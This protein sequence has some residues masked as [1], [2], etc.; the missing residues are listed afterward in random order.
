MRYRISLIV[1]GIDK[2]S[3]FFIIIAGLCCFFLMLLTCQQVIARYLWDASSI[4]IQEL[5]WH[6]FGCIFLL[7]SSG[8]LKDKGHVKVDILTSKFSE[9]TQRLLTGAGIILALIPTCLVLIIFGWDFVLQ[10]WDLPGT[11]S[12]KTSFF[13]QMVTKDGPFYPFLQEID[14]TIFHSFLRGERSPNPGGLPA[15][16]LIKGM[17]PL[18]ALLLFIQ[19]IGELL[20]LLVVRPNEDGARHR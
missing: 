20:K 11:F 9:N 4:A 16:W 3:A 2:I 19:G 12:E 15:R 17:I 8:T 14:Q 6:L 10:A 5:Q 7:G 1:A 18:G 13:S